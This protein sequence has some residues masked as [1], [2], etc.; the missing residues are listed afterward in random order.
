MPT[1]CGARPSYAAAL[2]R[3]MW[4]LILAGVQGFQP[5]RMLAPRTQRLRALGRGGGGGGNPGARRPWGLQRRRTEAPKPLSEE[6][7]R[8]ATQRMQAGRL[9]ARV[10]KDTDYFW[11]VVQQATSLERSAALLPL[12]GGGSGRDAA[13]AAEAAAAALAAV[14]GP[15][16]K[17]AS[18]RLSLDPSGA[19]L[20]ELGITPRTFRHSSASFSR[21]G[22]RISWGRGEAVIAAPYRVPQ[23]Q[24]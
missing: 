14:R 23:V 8:A 7:R 10:N 20:D 16:P 17:A 12:S 2:A 13:R 3:L 4:F 6:E 22:S 21:P 18:L 9:Q 24:V 15:P 5:G 19:G 11:R 1:D